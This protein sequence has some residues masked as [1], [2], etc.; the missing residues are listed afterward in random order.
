MSVFNQQPMGRSKFPLYIFYGFNI[1]FNLNVY[2][3]M[4][5]KSYLHFIVTLNLLSW[6]CDTCGAL[7]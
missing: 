3:N 7:Q 1:L 4:E 6:N 5:E 2:H